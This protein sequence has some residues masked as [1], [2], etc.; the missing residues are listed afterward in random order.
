MYTA[1]IYDYFGNDIKLEVDGDYQPYEPQEWGYHGGYPGCPEGFEVCEVLIAETGAE[2]CLI[3]Y[4]EE[5]IQDEILSQI[6]EDQDYAKYGYLM[7]Q[8][9]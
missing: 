1:T 5:E 3:G 9:E 8:G 2:V 6:H 7:D 4:A